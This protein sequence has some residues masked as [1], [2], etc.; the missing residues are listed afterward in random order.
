MPSSS[1][2]ISRQLNLGED[3][4]WEFKQVEFNGDHPTSPKRD[5]LG[6]EIAAFANANGGNLLCGVDDS[7][8]LQGLSRAQ[9]ENLERLIIEICTDSIRPPI[10]PDV[11]RRELDRKAFIHVTVPPGYAQHDSP[12]GSYLRVGSSKRPMTPDERT[13]L[14]QRRG[15][16]RFK[17]VD[18][19]TITDTGLATLDELLWRPLLS[20]EG[21]AEPEVALLKLG[22][23]RRDEYGVT[24]ATIAGA[25][26]CARQPE[27]LVSNASISAVQY[28]GVDRAS[29]QVDAQEITGPLAQQITQAVAF[30]M[31]NM[32]V[33]ARKMPERED[34]PEFS[35]RAIFE[36]VVN[37]VVHRDYSIR[38][39]R[40]RLSM[41]S[42]RIEICSPGALPNSLTVESMAERQSTRN[43][44]LASVLGRMDAS[45]TRGAA[46]RRYFMERRGDGVPIIR[47]ETRELSGR[48][49]EFRVI[50]DAEL[51]LLI[52][53]AKPVSESATAV[54]TVRCQGKPVAGA[55][56][57]ALF[58]NNT[59]RMAATNEHGEAVL[60]LHSV[61]LPMTVYAAAQACEAGIERS[62]IPSDRGLAFELPLL[63]LGGS[64]IFPE[65]TG[66]VPG[67]EGRL[68]PILDPSDRTC[69]YADNIAINGGQQPPVPF[70]PGEE[71]LHMVDSYGREARVRIVAISGR[72]SLLEYRFGPF[73]RKLLFED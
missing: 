13:R 16:S 73:D 27:Q 24:R 44:V 28:G 55:D 57:L 49:P 69:I 23:L 7:G 3:S 68:N 30:V 31:R 29:G 19:Q 70:I 67:L 17:G 54:V 59:W 5:D 4:A 18:E 40:I 37:A 62:W 35:E 34:L 1:E 25:L 48:E 71:V 6:D 20:G 21:A 46:A 45:Q 36:A 66:R 12:G 72:S 38:G 10:R 15:L 53:A 51:C 42:D 52:P 9:L 11:F 8:G 26:L 60:N 32:R 65:S 47:R 63:D 41:F 2:E 14:S 56:V 22:L 61:H 64:V 50:D 39:S 43:E 58:P 33:G